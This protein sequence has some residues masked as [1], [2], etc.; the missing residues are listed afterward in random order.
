MLHTVTADVSASRSP[1]PIVSFVISGAVIVASCVA[2]LAA[3]AGGP[4]SALV[5]YLAYRRTRTS[6]REHARGSVALAVGLF[7][8]V[9]GA[10]WF[11][12]ALV[13]SGPAVFSGPALDPVS[14]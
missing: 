11:G 13:V 8:L 4:V 2:P 6:A 3:L 9:A 12:V 7:P 10:L 5:G 1:W 14:R